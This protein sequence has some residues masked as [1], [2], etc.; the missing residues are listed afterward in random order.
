MTA[1]VDAEPGGD[2][3]A[4]AAADGEG[5][6]ELVAGHVERAGG[7]DEGRE[8]HGG[9]EDCGKSDGE[10]GVVLHPVADAA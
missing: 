10:D 5:D 3:V 7:E 2:G 9:W 1:V 8:R 4:D 6:E